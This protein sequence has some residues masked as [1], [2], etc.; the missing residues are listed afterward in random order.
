MGYYFSSYSANAATPHGKGTTTPPAVSIY[1]P[2]GVGFASDAFD[3]SPDCDT[4]I[5]GNLACPDA[6]A[7][8]PKEKPW[9]P[10]SFSLSKGT[11]RGSI[12]LTWTKPDFDGFSPITDYEYQ[13]DYYSVSLRRYVTYCNWT[14]AGTSMYKLISTQYSR[15][16][17]RVRMRAVNGEGTGDKTGY[18]LITTR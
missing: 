17:F 7:N 13:L 12:E 6:R 16:K 2:N 11:A 3:K 18:K 1:G 9:R 8:H 14:S 5:C 15:T 10:K 4:C